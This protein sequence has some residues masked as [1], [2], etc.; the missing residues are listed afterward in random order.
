MQIRNIRLDRF[1]GCSNLSLDSLTDGVNVIH[2]PAGSGKATL[3]RFLRSILY[4]FDDSTRRQY[5]PVDSRGFGGAVKV[6]TL[7]GLQSIAR[8]DDGS[9]S[10]RL[11][12]EAEDGS[13]VKNLTTT[14]II[15]A[16]PE[17]TFDRIY[18]VDYRRRPGIGALIE[19]AQASGLDLLGRGVDREELAILERQLRQQR[20][21]LATVP[22]GQ[23]THDELCNRRVE[24]L[25][26]IGELEAALEN[27]PDEVSLT[28]QITRLD[29]QLNDWKAELR[30]LQSELEAALS[31]RQQIFARRDAKPNTRNLEAPQIQEL[32][33]LVAQIERWQCTLREVTTRRQ[34]LEETAEQVGTR[35]LQ[36]DPRRC[37]GEIEGQL[38]DVQST[39]AGLN[40]P[41]SYQGQEIRSM[42]TDVF[43]ELRA[44]VYRLCNQLTYWETTTR[45]KDASCE[46]KDLIRCEAELRLAIAGAT[47]RK[48][49]LQREIEDLFGDNAAKLSPWFRENCECTEHPQ[50]QAKTL[51]TEIRDDGE[52]ELSVIS[53][54]LAELERGQDRL[55]A[56]VDDIESELSDLRAQLRLTDRVELLDQL[57]A[58]RA[59]LRR[60]E[61]NLRDVDRR[62]ELLAE[63]SATEE[64]IEDLRANS[65]AST[66]LSDASEYLRRLTAGDLR[67]IDVAVN[68]QVW[69]IDEHGRRRAYHQLSD[70]GRDLVYLSIC[71]TI[72]DGFKARGIDVPML[73]SGVFT[74]VD[75]KNVPEAAELLRDFAARGHQML[76]FTRHEHVAGVFR[77][78]NVPIRTLEYVALPAPSVAETDSLENS[79]ESDGDFEFTASS[80]QDNDTHETFLLTEH[81]A[82][83]DAPAIDTINAGRLRKIGVMR[84]GDLLRL[85]AKAAA[86]DLNEYG[87]TAEQIVS[88][89]SQTRLVCEV[90]RL[91]GYDARILVACGITEPEQLYRLSPAELRTIVKDVA[92]SSTGQALL[93]SGTEFEL[94][95]VADWIGTHDLRSGTSKSSSTRSES[96]RTRS[97]RA[98]SSRSS[99]SERDGRTSSR[100]AGSSSEPTRQRSERSSGERNE[101]NRDPNVVKMR[102]NDGPLKFY[103]G[104]NDAIVDAPSI[105]ARTAERLE[106][107][108]ITSVAD[109]LKADP[110]SVS[111]QLG[112]K[113]FTPKVVTQ[114][115]RQTELA[116]RVPQLRGHDA[117]ILVALDITT[118]EQI[119]ASDPQELWSFVKPFVETKEG[120]RIIR[121]GKTPDLEEVTDWIRWAQAAR[122]LNAA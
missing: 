81:D 86:I 116:C 37:L 22:R 83:E 6:R 58:K 16:I 103:L 18:S 40:D 15:A 5:L 85:S 11:T 121:N 25:R 13:S 56:D 82:I 109:L 80:E 88:W 72:V 55:V 20:D 101:R 19:E 28:D 73:V 1:G 47:T 9:D 32:N 50:L 69:V 2:G 92:A 42:F 31:R 44:N 45:H 115:Q 79:C 46:A 51:V 48:E 43:A 112:V 53:A 120:K 60:V 122:L 41:Q 117:Q 30:T 90:P 12:I 59:E 99:S 108:G 110:E 100:E 106:V 91:R 14:E 29:A 98:S 76:L 36:G 118:A 67:K 8:I 26:L 77:L 24:L 119:A 49:Q 75:S 94:S 96:S 84:V 89:K 21:S 104:R 23:A 68:E 52:S 34:S 70:G 64:E 27:Q 111:D 62:R 4:G 63:I 95:R 39:L 97:T 114:W 107:L 87:I 102:S 33:E 113:R 61:Q 74:H 71:L 66:L 78:L 105:G 65:R 10:G 57:D 3:G 7:L 38:D 93:M 54:K 17:S 35:D